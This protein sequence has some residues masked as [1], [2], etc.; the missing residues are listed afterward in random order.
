M[1]SP[2][3]LHGRWQ[4]IRAELSGESAPEE[5]VGRTILEITATGYRVEFDGQVADAGDFALLETSS[6]RI[7]VLHGR[8]GPNAGRVIRGLLQQVG[9]RL[10]ICY[11]LDAT[12]PAAFTTAVGDARYL[13]TYRRLG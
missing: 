6:A 10:R 5:V 12:V 1:S 11:G 4:M 2:N 8:S 7:L 9:D 13:A 3:P